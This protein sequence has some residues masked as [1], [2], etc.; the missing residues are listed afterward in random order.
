MVTMPVL[1]VSCKGILSRREHKIPGYV[2]RSQSQGVGSAQPLELVH[3]L[4]I[5]FQARFLQEILPYLP[6]FWTD[7][8][9][10]IFQTRTD[11]GIKYALCNGLT[12]DGQHTFGS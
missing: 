8:K 7:H 5:D 12:K 4:D 6:V 11:Q 10:K 3:K 9:D 2:R 1:T